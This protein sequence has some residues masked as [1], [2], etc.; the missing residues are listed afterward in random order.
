[1]RLTRCPDLQLSLSRE[2]CS[3]LSTMIS[4]YPH[5]GAH[6]QVVVRLRKALESGEDLHY[7]LNPTEAKALDAIL[8]AVQPT[9]AGVEARVRMDF[10]T[11]FEP[12]KAG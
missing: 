4:R 7:H 5:D 8:T 9:T 2:E 10:H 1:M 6:L 12:F 11:Q 3:S